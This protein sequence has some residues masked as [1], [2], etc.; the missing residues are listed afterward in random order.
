MLDDLKGLNLGVDL[1][2]VTFLLA[3]GRNGEQGSQG[4]VL[5]RG[6]IKLETFVLLIVILGYFHRVVGARSIRL[7][8][9]SW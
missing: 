6:L 4:Y 8:K 3:K 5:K 2:F 1:T 9:Q 7:V